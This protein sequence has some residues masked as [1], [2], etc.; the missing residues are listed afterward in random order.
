MF[1]DNNTVIMYN[2]TNEDPTAYY[3]LPRN[4]IND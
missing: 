1:L 2:I 4:K 3:C